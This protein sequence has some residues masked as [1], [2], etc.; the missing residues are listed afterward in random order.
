MQRSLSLF[1]SGLFVMLVF[2]AQA[3]EQCKS[4]GTT[5][6]LNLSLRDEYNAPPKYKWFFDTETEFIKYNLNVNKAH[7]IAEAER[8]THG[9]VDEFNITERITY[10]VN[11]D[12]TVG[13][14]QGFRVL[15]MKEIEDEDH[16]GQHQHS[17][18]PNDLDVSFQYRFMHQKKEGGFP[19]DLSLFASF[20]APSGVTHN[21]NPQGEL[22][23][24]EDQ[25][26]TGS[27]NETIGFSAAKR[28][29]AWSATAAYGYTHKG[30]GSQ[31]FKEGDINRFTMS[32]SRQMIGRD[33]GWKLFLSQGLQFFTE[34]KS[35]DHGSKSPDHGGQFIYAAPSV[36]VQPIDRLLLSATAAVPLYQEEN[37]FHQRDRFGIQLNIGVRF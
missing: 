30:E 37:G 21:H 29:G 9:H 32:G 36:I 25:P 23:E 17:D 7:Q 35:I 4:L 13:I 5:P 3:C 22:F 33:G 11:K 8:D 19:V 2:G 6:A 31:R 28:W 26:G 18:G 16:L 1:V 24:T 34:N 10:S 15:R 20:K 27:W 14:A 12:I